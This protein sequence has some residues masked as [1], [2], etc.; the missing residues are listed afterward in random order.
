MKK[1]ILASAFALPFAATAA[2]AAG[3]GNETAPPKP[4]CEEGMVYDKA[5]KTCV[6]AQDSN[7]DID[8]LYENLRELAHAGRYDDAQAVL[9]QMPPDDDRTLT[10]LGFTSRKMGQMDLAMT[11]YERALAVNP[12]NVLA[13]S[14]MGQGFVEQGKIQDALAQLREIRAH[15][16]TGTWAETSLRDAIATGR[17]YSY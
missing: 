9:A 10:Y 17:T 16:G 1:I 13:R 11:Y 2:L 7:L 4:K 14:Y 15:G 5:T 6:N 3:G 8:G 12:S